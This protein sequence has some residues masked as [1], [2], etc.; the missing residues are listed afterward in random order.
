MLQIILKI[1]LIAMLII[2]F[3]EDIRHREISL[4][5]L[6]ATFAMVLALG[7]SINRISLA[8]FGLNLLF[9]L[10]QV[11]FL[12]FY[13]LIT[14]RKPS[15]LLKSYL[16]IGDI[17]F[18]L[19]PAFYFQLL[20][21]ILFSLVCYISVVSGYGI[22]FLIKRK[23]ITIPLAGLMALFMGIYMILDWNSNCLISNYVFS[24]INIL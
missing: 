11:A 7:F 10:L 3:I 21:F 23:P 6:L 15:M 2:L 22:L 20:E 13:L 9:I 16:G 4:F 14:R 1:V 19:I 18:W 8:E 12:L 24:V 5:L 17:L